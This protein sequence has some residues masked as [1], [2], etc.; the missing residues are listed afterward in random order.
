MSKK[1]RGD[2]V[3]PRHALSSCAGAASPSR[4]RASAEDDARVDGPDGTRSILRAVIAVP[5]TALDYAQVVTFCR[6]HLAE[7]KVPRSVILVPDLP[8]TDRGKNDRAAL[9]ALAG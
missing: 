8:R 6:A 1:F 9:A 7:H 4:S 5:S 2:A 3:H